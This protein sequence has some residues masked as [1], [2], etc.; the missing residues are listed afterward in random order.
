MSVTSDKALTVKPELPS[1]RPNK[2]LTGFHSRGSL[3]HLKREGSC[4]FVTFRLAGTLPAEVLLQFKAEREAIIHQAEAAKRPLT[5]H[6]REEL[7]R[8]YSARVDKYLDASHGDCWLKRENLATLVVK[9][10]KFHAGVRFDLQ[11][12]IVM[13]NHVHVVVHPVNQWTLSKIL[14]SWKGYTSREANKILN[15]TGERFWQKEAYNHLIRDD[16]DLHR[17]CQYT[18]HNPVDAGLCKRAGEWRW[19][20]VYDQQL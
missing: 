11:Q 4:Y 20:S 12:W 17:C 2:L 15:R 7:F 6:E 14:Q 10:L 13:P 16:E 18:M 9:A 8:W 1:E 3:P 5:W 19:S